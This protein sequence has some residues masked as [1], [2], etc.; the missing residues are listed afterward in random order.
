MAADRGEMTD[1][2]VREDG[3]RDGRVGLKW[4]GGGGGGG[5]EWG[6]VTGAGAGCTQTSRA[7]QTGRR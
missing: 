6:G 5:R 3:G 4:G 1:M 7:P 2:V